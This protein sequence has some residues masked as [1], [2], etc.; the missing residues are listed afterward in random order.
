MDRLVRCL[1]LA[2]A[3]EAHF[4]KLETEEGYAVSLIRGPRFTGSMKDV[5]QQLAQHYGI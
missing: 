4:Y 2:I 3:E 1:E 5:L